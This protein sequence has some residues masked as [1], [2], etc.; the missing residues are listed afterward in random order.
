M[1]RSCRW[2]PAVEGNCRES[3]NLKWKG[4]P[5]L[6]VV[7]YGTGAAADAGKG[8]G[9]GKG[10]SKLALSTRLQ[11]APRAAPVQASASVTAAATT[12]EVPSAG[13]H[14][15]TALDTHHSHAAN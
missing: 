10:K 3:F 12:T 13:E 7:L 6:Q 14:C 15:A 1:L 5:P 11:R 8:K 2:I 4:R 9:K